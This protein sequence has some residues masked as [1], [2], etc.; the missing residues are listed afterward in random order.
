MSCLLLKEYRK[1]NYLVKY[2]KYKLFNENKLYENPSL[3]TFFPTIV[4][5]L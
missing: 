5:K 4:D 2:N 3:Y 1:I